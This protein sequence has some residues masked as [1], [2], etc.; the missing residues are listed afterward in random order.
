MRHAKK[1]SP[2]RHAHFTADFKAE[3]VR[4][5]QTSGHP[6]RSIV[7]DLRLQ[8]FPVPNNVACSI[9]LKP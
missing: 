7:E 8:F 6:L 4:L 9:A 2:G 1:H 5:A 3:A